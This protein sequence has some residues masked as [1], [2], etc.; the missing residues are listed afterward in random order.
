LNQPFAPPLPRPTR[1]LVATIVLIVLA[2]AGVVGARP[3][4]ADPGLGWSTFLGG[5]DVD[6]ANDVAID[7][8]GDVYVVGTTHSP[9]FPTSSGALQGSLDGPFVAFVTKLD[10]NGA[11]LW[12]TYLGGSGGDSAE[13]VEVDGSGNVYVAGTTGSTD[14]PTT[15]GTDRS[16]G[17]LLDTFVAK[18][19]STG[20]LSY[21][22]YLGGSDSD[23][24]RGIAIDSAG[25]AY[26]N[27]ITE[28]S[29]FPVSAGAPDT[30]RSQD[31]GFVTK[32]SANGRSRIYSTFL[33]GSSYEGFDSE[34]TGDVA[35]DAAGNA[36]VTG[37][38]GSSDFP[39]TVGV[40]DRTLG[41]V[42]DAY[43]TKINAAG[44]AFTYSMLLG[45]SS[46]E[47]GWDVV[48]DSSQ[49][50]FVVGDTSSTDYP[51]TPGAW[52]L[53]NS[54]PTSQTTQAGFVTKIS[55]T[56]AALDYSTYLDDSVIGDVA[57]D[58]SGRAYVTGTAGP[59]FPATTDAID[60]IHNDPHPESGLGD[61][62]FV[63]RFSADG[64][65]LEHATFLG[66]TSADYGSALAQAGGSDVVA[67]GTT[68]SPDFPITS[69]ALQTAYGELGDG[70]VTKLST[71]PI[72][73]YPR[74]RG[75]TPLSVS[76]VPAFAE[77]SSA[78]RTHGAPLSYSSCAPPTQTSSALTIGTP[79]ANGLAAD[80]A[81]RVTLRVFPG[82]PGTLDSE[83]NVYIGVDLSGVRRRDTLAP[84]AGDIGLQIVARVTDVRHGRVT[85][86]DHTLP[87]GTIP[88]SADFGCHTV[89]TVNSWLP[90]AI[91]E[92]TRAIWQL[93]Q[94]NLYDPGPDGD[95]GTFGDDGLFATQGVFIP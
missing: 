10:P 80:S 49:D 32:L 46:L 91:R 95:A 70:F 93:E 53:T 92:G 94:V 83:S 81:G 79:D 3:A 63:G 69:G 14:F 44:T 37:T 7:T 21:S 16:F 73:G 29:D 40:P 33:G 60:P 67:V 31:E 52:D 34:T 24:S 8:N 61:D 47:E 36:Y 1:L 77:C 22:T 26:V 72:P 82:D 86:E 17:G 38:T 78:N 76:L 88:C 13:A 39:T 74:P 43:L 30:V 35:V 58:G 89:T 59:G 55:R 4:L 64:S 50:A 20:G 71:E 12:S 90:G 28:S 84:Y 87:L 54:P 41:G 85:V 48:V 68:G 45:G 2:G 15:P 42:Q 62:A 56:G 75:A 19:T 57:I 51:T 6:G 65:N 25:E 9:N 27:G 11:L 18:L 66:G 5:S 23:W